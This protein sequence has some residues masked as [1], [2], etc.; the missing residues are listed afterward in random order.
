LLFIEK[1][2]ELETSFVEISSEVVETDKVQAFKTLLGQKPMNGQN[3]LNRSMEAILSNYDNDETSRQMEE[4][5][6]ANHELMEQNEDLKQKVLETQA[7]YEE[8]SA[9]TDLN[10]GR[11]EGLDFRQ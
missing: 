8:N 11:K 6:Q 1:L 4:L 3:D 2:R 9:H 7:S 5:I 10:R